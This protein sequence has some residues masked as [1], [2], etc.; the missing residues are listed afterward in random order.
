MGGSS[1][2]SRQVGAKWTD[3]GIAGSM[4]VLMVVWVDRSCSS[5]QMGAKWTNNG[6]AGSMVVLMVVWVDW[7]D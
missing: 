3:R 1:C 6:I 7:T 5:G 4:V 2:S